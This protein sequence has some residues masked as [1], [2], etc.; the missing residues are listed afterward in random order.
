MAKDSVDLSK[1][2]P[3]INE[4]Y[5]WRIDINK[6]VIIRKKKGINKEI[7]LDRY[8]SLVWHKIDG[9]KTVGEIAGE[10]MKE[11][12]E[13]KTLACKR[14]EMFFKMLRKHELICY[15]KG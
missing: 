2:I 4:E 11:L 10:I 5:F 1:R 6:K 13:E 3:V 12:G 7:E 14:A 8:G 15:K 9:K